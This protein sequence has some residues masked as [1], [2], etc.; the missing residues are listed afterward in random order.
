[1]SDPAW[2]HRLQPTRLPSP[3]DSPGKNTGVGFHFLLQ[4]MKV[5]SESDVTQSCPTLSYPMDCSPLIGLHLLSSLVK[6]CYTLPFGIQ[7]RSWRLEFVPPNRKSRTESLPC[8]GSYWVLK[9]HLSQT[10][11]QISL[12]PRVWQLS[13]LP[14]ADV[15]HDPQVTWYTQAICLHVQKIYIRN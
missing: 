7:G 8:P 11:A 15:C 12:S 10:I 9:C 14:R 5:K 6:N 1:M 4:C 13:R 2:P 3:W